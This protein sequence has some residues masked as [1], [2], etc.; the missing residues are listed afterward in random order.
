MIVVDA[1]ALV[2]WLLG[3]VPRGEAV[4]AR[5]LAARR[6]HTLDLSTLEV[7]SAFRR[8]VGRGLMDVDRA[9]VAL[10]C[11]ADAPFVRHEVEAFAPRVWALRDRLSPY[12]AAYVALAEAL[13]AP[14]V[15][16]DARLARAHGHN[17]VVIDA[18]SVS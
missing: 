1:S 7:I 17:V 6:V 11:L 10:A 2:D 3:A 16:T 4:R 8:L 15:T 13:A 12:D 5:L 18:S 14:L 9:G